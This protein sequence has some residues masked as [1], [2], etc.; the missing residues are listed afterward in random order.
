MWFILAA[1]IV[2]LCLLLGVVAF[3]YRAGRQSARLSALKRE[4]KE[5]EKANKILNAVRNLDDNAVRER[6][7]N[8]PKEERSDLR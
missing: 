5:R 2:G 3:V 8:I 6:L 7:H 1:L 4:I